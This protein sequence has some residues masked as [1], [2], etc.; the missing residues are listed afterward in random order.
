MKTALRP[1][2]L[3]FL[4]AAVSGQSVLSPYNILYTLNQLGSVPGV[5]PSYGG[6]TFLASDPNFLLI[7]G[8]ANGTTGQVFKIRVARDPQGHVTGF[9]GTATVHCSAQYLD[10]GVAY[11]PGRVLFVTQYPFNQLLQCVRLTRGGDEPI[12]TA[13][14]QGHLESV[15]VIKVVADHRLVDAGALGHGP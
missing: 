15:L 12:E 11:G 4:G 13:V 9:L 14:E 3:A 10:G 5:P 2:V 1:C 7:G 8:A 6:L